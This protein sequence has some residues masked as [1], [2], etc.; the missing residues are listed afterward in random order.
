MVD[1]S[2]TK[3]AMADFHGSQIL[4]DLGGI[5]FS[6]IMTGAVSFSSRPAHLQSRPLDHWVMTLLLSGHTTTTTPTHSF[7]CRPGIVQVHPLGRTFHGKASDSEMLMLWIPRDFCRDIAR[8]L[9]SAEFSILDTAMGRM[10]AAFM[11]GLGNQAA[12]LRQDEL[13]QLLAATREMILACVAPNRAYTEDAQ[14]AI[15]AL[16]LERARQFIQNNLY[17]Q[18]LGAEMLMRELAISRTRL[19][20]LFEPAGGV[21][22]YIQ[23]RRLLDA[24]SVLA[25]PN[26]NR[27]I[28]EIA[29]Q[30]GFDGAE[31]SRAF[32]RE[33]GYSPSDVRKGERASMPSYTGA[34]LASLA[35]KERLGSLLWRLQTGEKLEARDRAVS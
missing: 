6:R 16:L 19:Y 12:C 31:F 25:D 9:D 23:H 26:E 35:P 11:I 10:F 17:S 15:F 28:L 13:P 5:G 29:E 1:L 27:K 21:N 30:R 8:V 33:F 34:D 18:K 7:D 4:W 24:H 32:R 2:G 22:R 14:R 20:R 3:E